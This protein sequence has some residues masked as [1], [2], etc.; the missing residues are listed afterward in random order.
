MI[1]SNQYQKNHTLKEKAYRIIKAKI[2]RCE[3]APGEVLNEKALIEEI[4]ASRTPIR[5]ALSRIEQENLVRIIPKRG[6][7]IQEITMTDIS[8]IYQIREVL[9]PF[10]TE[11][12]TPN[13]PENELLKYQQLFSQVADLDYLESVEIDDKF[14]NFILKS[15]NNSY[16]VQ[17]MNNIYVQNQ[18][19]RVLSARLNNR[20]NVS[21]NEHLD[22]ISKLLLR[23]A[24]KAAEAMRIHIINSKKAAF[25]TMLNNQLK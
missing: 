4:G 9:D 6:V 12:A 19:I 23:D 14:H 13:V 15:C 8:E 3:L 21:A 20:V 5:E 24:N 7:F 16:L 10:I 11:L 2:A 17:M 22:I 1:S 25:E 18:R